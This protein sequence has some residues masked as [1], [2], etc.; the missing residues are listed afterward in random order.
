MSSGYRLP[1]FGHP[2]FL[3]HP[4]AFC[5][6]GGGLGLA[7]VNCLQELFGWPTVGLTPNSRTL[8]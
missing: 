5:Q 8:T 1:D 2:V 3:Q 7:Q 6:V 4:R